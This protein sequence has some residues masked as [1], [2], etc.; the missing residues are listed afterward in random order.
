MFCG[1]LCE[2]HSRFADVYF[3]SSC[4]PCPAYFYKGLFRERPQCV[5]ETIKA[6]DFLAQN[7]KEMKEDLQLE[8]L[9]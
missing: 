9:I 6:Y 3:T 2:L 8:F 1:I 4:S 7:E 5:V